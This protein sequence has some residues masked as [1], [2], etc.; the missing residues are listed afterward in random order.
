V[1]FQIGRTFGLLARTLPFIFFRLAIY[2]GIAVAYVLATAVGAGI[3]HAVNKDGTVVGGL[4][5]FGLVAGALYWLR[6]YILY[7]VKAGNIAVLVELMDGREPP[8]GKGQVAYAQQQVR[9]H[10][11]QTSV[12]FGVDQLVKGVLNMITGAFMN[13][14]ELL[15]IPGIDTVTGI[16]NRV[17]KLS[18]TYVDE[19]ILA[20]NLRHGDDNPWASS[21]DGLILY[22]QNYK[23]FL[24]NGVFLALI[25][26]VLSFV[27]F[28]VV[29]APAA[30]LTIALPGSAGVWA[31]LIALVFAWAVKKAVL[32]PFAMTALMTVYFETVEGQTPDPEWEQRLSRLSDKFVEIKKKAVNYVSPR[33]PVSGEQEAAE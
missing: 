11:V 32:E 22:G 18:L 2:I 15:P 6:E 1:D 3:G 31:F 12:L 23:T 33:K 29:L 13:V 17:I 7:L 30:G 19:V 25:L 4:V 27:V 20:Y 10:F 5:G 28:L 16:I 14:S 21:R 8:G 24:K 9:A 26:W